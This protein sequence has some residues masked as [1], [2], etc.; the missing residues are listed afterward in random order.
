MTSLIKVDTIQTSAGGSPTASSLGIG[1][2]GKIGQVIEATNGSMTTI[3]STSYFD[4]GLTASI[5]P[6]STSSKVL[7]TINFATTMDGGSNGTLGFG[8]IYH[9][10]TT[11]L[12]ERIAVYDTDFGNVGP[13]C[14]IQTLHSPNSTSSQKYNLYGKTLNASSQFRPNGTGS[15][16]LMEVLA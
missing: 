7:I 11:N 13:A 8:A 14:S 2:V 4:T 15:I 10:D 1:G 5:T 16:I 9:N 12:R 3:T 6:S